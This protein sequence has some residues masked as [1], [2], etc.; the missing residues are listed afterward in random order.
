MAN[1]VA[2]FMKQQRSGY[3]INTSSM[4]GKRALPVYGIY[5]ASKFGLLGYAEAL[6]KELIPYGIKVTTICPSTVATDM[7]KDF[8]I[9]GK[10]MIQTSDMVS[11][12]RFLLSLGHTAAIQEIMIQCTEFARIEIEAATEKFS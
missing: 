12:V 8:K 6:F 7:T 11:T 2:A 4:A 3:I 10:L 9:S 5:S 1:A